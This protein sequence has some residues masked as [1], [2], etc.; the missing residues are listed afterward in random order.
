[1]N[2]P[3]KNGPLQDRSP[4]IGQGEVRLFAVRPAQ[5]GPLQV[6]TGEIRSVTSDLG[7]V[8]PREVR[9]GRFGR[10]PRR[11]HFLP[12]PEVGSRQVRVVG[13]DPASFRRGAYPFRGTQIAAGEASAAQRGARQVDAAQ[14]LA[15]EDAEPV[16]PA[17]GEVAAFALY[18]TAVHP[19]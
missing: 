4:E 15:L 18:S 14:V 17:A 11:H 6:G 10:L 2:G 5:V 13:F 12:R 3:G 8:G 9:P 7:Q 1:E 19:L 16:E